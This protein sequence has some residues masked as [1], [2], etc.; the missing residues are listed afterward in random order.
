METQFQT[1]DTTV[2]HQ[3]V[4]GKYR[5]VIERAASTKGVLGYKVE[6]NEDVMADA[7]RFAEK[8]KN[9]IERITGITVQTGGN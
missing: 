3:T 6:V 8:L 7:L 2:V 4:N 9:E 1:V 5:I